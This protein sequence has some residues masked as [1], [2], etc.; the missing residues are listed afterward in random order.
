MNHGRPGYEAYAQEKV[1]MYSKLAER[2]QRE[3]KNL[4]Y[5]SALDQED[6]Q[7]LQDFIIAQRAKYEENK[8][9]KRGLDVEQ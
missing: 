7:T 6:G 8:R 2:G 1:H 9:C 3:F 5:K 4:W